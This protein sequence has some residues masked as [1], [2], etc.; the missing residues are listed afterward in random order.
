MYIIN[1]T[2]VQEDQSVNIEMTADRERV[3]EENILNGPYRG[4]IK[5]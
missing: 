2:K 5:I 1:S 3:T 4:R